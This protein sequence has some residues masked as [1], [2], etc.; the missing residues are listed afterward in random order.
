MERAHTDAILATL[1]DTLSAVVQAMLVTGIVQGVLAGMAYWFCGLPFS[2][3][4][5]VL[6]AFVSLI[7]YAVPLVWVSCAVYLASSGSVGAAIFLSIYG[8]TVISSVDNIVRPLVIGERAKLS[9][10]LLFF[11]ILGGLSVYGFLGLLLGPVVVA[12]VVT[13]LQIYREEYV[14]ERLRLVLRSW[15]SVSEVS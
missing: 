3:F 14:D 5:G 9:A 7:P 10:F 1:Y 12:T 2:L 15:C 13:F 4:L 6:S 8:V 11:A